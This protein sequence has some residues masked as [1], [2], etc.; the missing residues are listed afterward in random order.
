MLVKIV[1][2]QTLP[3][4]QG[5]EISP[6]TVLSV[7]K[8]EALTLVLEG[9]ARYAEEVRKS[10]LRSASERLIDVIRKGHSIKLSGD[11]N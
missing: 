3:R 4:Y 6:G 10:F 1:T 8:K 2:L 7:P 11:R 5:K 9:K